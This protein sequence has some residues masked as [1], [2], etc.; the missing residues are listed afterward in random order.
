MAE[1]STHP[2]ECGCG[3]LTGIAERTYGQRGIRKGDAY[4]F[5]AGHKPPAYDVDANGCWVG[6]G[7]NSSGYAGHRKR[8]ERFVGPVPEGLVLDHLCKNRA[9]VNPDHL[10]P[11][12]Q[13][14]NLLRILGDLCGKGHVLEGSNVWI[15]PQGNRRCRA[16]NAEKS[17]R[18]RAREKMKASC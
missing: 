16:C 7:L 4:R 17:R 2:C 18:H 10:E 5:I 12:T 9:C 15:T 3:R 1:L 8:Y 13:S 11:V 6:R 14:E